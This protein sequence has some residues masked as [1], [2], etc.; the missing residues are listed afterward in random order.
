MIK[1]LLAPF[2]LLFCFLYVLSCS[3]DK[4]VSSKKNQSYPDFHY[5]FS[6]VV[7]SSSSGS[8]AGSRLPV[9]IYLDATYSMQGFAQPQATTFSRLLGGIEAVVQNAAKSSEIKFYKYGRSVAPLERDAFV[10]ARNSPSLW[11]DKGFR[12]ETNFAQ[13]VD[14]VDPSRVSIFITDLFYSNADANKVV[15]AIQ[16]KCFKNG[17]E[18]GLLGLKSE[19]NGYVADVQPPVKVNGERPL[20]LLVFGSKANIGLIFS[21]FRNQPYV[22][23]DQALLLTRYPIKSFTAEAKKAKESK[24][25]NVSS[26]RKQF[27]DIGNIYAFNWNPDKGSK[28]TIEY[29]VNFKLEPYALPVNPQNVKARIYRK[30][31]A[32]KDSLVDEQSLNLEVLKADPAKFTGKA[33]VNLDLKEGDFSAYQIVWE[34]DNLGKIQL[35]NWVTDNSTQDFRQGSNEN[36]TLELETLVRSLV[37]NSATQFEPKY[38]KMYLVFGR[39]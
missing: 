19:F 8:K 21:A 20:Y 15:A 33:T 13:A 34:Y 32:A 38:G 26:I 36:K 17:V 9:D 30:D 23:A 5:Y 16:D 10:A 4:E 31:N 24:S 12:S 37:V 7:G 14:S 27:A 2:F 29:T 3:S 22:K 25:I 11:D 6:D 28:A 39:K 1:R 35:P 18:V